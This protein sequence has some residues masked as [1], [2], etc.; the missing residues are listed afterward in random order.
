[1]LYRGDAGQA[2][3]RS[4]RLSQE[5]RGLPRV[6]GDLFAADLALAAPAAA[7]RR[8]GPQLP[9]E[10]STSRAMVRYWVEMLAAYGSPQPAVV[11]DGPYGLA[12]GSAEHPRLLA[13][14]PTAARRTVTFRAEGRV[15]AKVVVDP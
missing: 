11:A 7:R 4:T 8:L 3:A 14:N 13:V 5:V 2:A 12:F 1:S 6:W 10:E 9:R 15:L